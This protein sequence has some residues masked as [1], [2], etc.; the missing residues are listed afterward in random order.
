ML[1]QKFLQL[2]DTGAVRRGNVRKP[3]PGFPAGEVSANASSFNLSSNKI[4][5]EAMWEGFAFNLGL[6]ERIRNK[7]M[8]ALENGK[9]LWPRGKKGEELYFLPNKITPYT[10]WSKYVEDGR[11]TV[12]QIKDGKPEGLSAGWHENGQ[13]ASEGNRKDGK[14]DGPWTEWYKNGQKKWEGNHKDGRLIS[15]LAWKPN[16]E[17][18]PM[19]NLKNGN[20]IVVWYNDNGTE[21]GRLTYKDG[22]LVD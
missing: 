9:V 21:K 2:I 5:D 22:E 16:G 15:A 7:M 13:K 11:T 12:S 14:V 6:T 10:G 17:K 20:G 3:G 8:A 19:T 4:I 1:V 18:C